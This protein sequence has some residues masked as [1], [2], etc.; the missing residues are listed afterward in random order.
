MRLIS[1]F[2]YFPDNFVSLAPCRS[3]FHYN[4]HVTFLFLSPKRKRLENFPQPSFPICA[5]VLDLE[6]E[7][8]PQELTV[9]G[10]ISIKISG[11]KVLVLEKGIDVLVE[12]V[13]KK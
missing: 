2:P 8:P 1:Q 10:I 3:R 13:R 9:F 12:F 4:D 11:N 5:M 7:L 6:L